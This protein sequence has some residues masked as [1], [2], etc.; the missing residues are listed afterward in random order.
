MNCH[1]RYMMALGLLASVFAGLGIVQAQTAVEKKSK[2]TT[3]AA[4]DKRTTA[5]STQPTTVSQPATES[6]P[7]K[8]PKPKTVP[9]SFKNAPMEQI[10]KFL[11]EQMGKPVIFKEVES[12]KVT[13]VNPKPLP[14]AEAMD[15]LTTALH[16]HGVAIEERSKT[17]HLIPISKVSQ[18]RIKTIPTDASLTGLKP[19][20]IVRKFFLVRH[21][22]A[23]KLVDVLKPLMPTWGHITADPT[24][25]RLII[26]ATVEH[27]ALLSQIITEL[28]KPD[29]SGGELGVF[30][31]NHVDVYEIIPIL[32]KLIAGYLGAEATAISA[33]GGAPGKERSSARPSR[34]G[35]PRP[36]GPPGKGKGKPAAA[37]A[38]T[39]EAEK[40]AVLL[41][42]DARRSVLVVA[43]PS[44]VL[45]QIKVWLVTLDQAKPPSTQ[46]EIVE[47]QFGDA[48]DFAS[49]LTD[50]LN[51][52]PDEGLRTALRIFPFASS[53]RLIIVGS[54]QNR[55]MI[56]DWLKEID[57]EDT[58][59]RITETFTLKYADAQKVAENI[60]ELFGAQQMRVRYMF[61]PYRRRA[62]DRHVVSVTANVRRNSITVVASPEKMKKIAEQIADWDKPFEGEEAAPRIYTLKYADPEKTKE[63]LESLF[64]KKQTGRGWRW[65][66]EEEEEMAA[67]VGRLFGQFR[68]EA[69]P[70]TGKLIVVSKNDEN[71]QYIEDI[72]EKI[73]KAEPASVPRIIQL[74]FADAETLAEQLNAL[75]NAPGTPTSILR[76]GLVRPFQ[77]FETGSP[78]AQQR[79][80]QR[81]QQQQRDSSLTQMRFWWQ[82]HPS[83]TKVKQPSNLV[84]KLRIVPN[85]E[86]N[87]LLVAAPDEYAA[88]IEQFIRD[89]DK[90]SYQVLVK[91]V[92]A[93]ITHED[94]TSLGFR[95]STDPSLFTTGADPLIT[96]NALRGLLNYQFTDTYGQEHTLSLN[97]DVN[98]LIS[99]LRRVTDIKIKSEPGVVAADNME[100]EFFDGQDIPFIEESRSTP[101]GTLIQT[102]DYKEVGIRLRVKPHITK[103][104]NIDLTV[105]LLVSNTV[106]GRTLFGGA[107]VDRRETTSRVVLEDGAT[108]LISGILREEQRKIIRRIPGL[109]DIPL[110]GEIFKHREL[111]DVNSE[112]LIFLTPYVVG[113]KDDREPSELAPI[114]SEPLQRL[115]ELMD[116]DSVRK[117]QT[118]PANSIR[119]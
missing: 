99:L 29:V 39:I 10:A 119:K 34:R 49:Q 74:K 37:G 54:E 12:I 64:T 104:R 96:E 77:D 105:N 73:D 46:Y 79:D 106:P 55:K 44:N 81:N 89:L 117:T 3:K 41:I 57:I 7:A 45:E 109:G 59:L 88:D 56:K 38:I 95:F 35:P 70:E 78:F 36:G 23:A 43:A 19:N 86:Q 48:E 102:F 47:V 13:L 91:A 71:Y 92:I 83:E 98:N 100:A 51:K 68:F 4:A 50:L 28:D 110:V 15:I 22:D 18:A 5:P 80:D 75:L 58:G 14:P 76:R 11:F 97:V 62:P 40:K 53:R 26:V 66:W 21:Y 31:I 93:T 2:P 24:T 65:P 90:P 60:K 8:P 114:E 20:E 52:I 67:P 72:I 42:P 113:P 107:I 25:G 118:Q 82:Q 69:Y 111:A 116:D 112:L 9:L 103:D 85:L 30:H 108:F 1:S 6:K 94:A 115:K 87:L 61:G 101:E 16:E 32:Q 63:L 27:L 17:V 33:V 84:G